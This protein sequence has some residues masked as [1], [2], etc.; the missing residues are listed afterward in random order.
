MCYGDNNY[1]IPYL[2][3]D[4]LCDAVGNLPSSID[5]SVAAKDV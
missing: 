1:K 4:K 5:V 2:G 3:K